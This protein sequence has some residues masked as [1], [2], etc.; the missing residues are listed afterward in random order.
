[1]LVHDMSFIERRSGETRRYV[2]S[3]FAGLAVVIALM[4]VVIAELSWRGWVQ[5]M[6]ALLHGEGLLRRP[7]APAPAV[8]PGFQPI[9]RDLQR[10]IHKLALEAHSRDESQITWTADTLRAILSASSRLRPRRVPA[11]TSTSPTPPRYG[12]WPA[13]SMS[14]SAGAGAPDRCRFCSRSST[15]N[16]RRSTNITGPRSCASS[17][18]CMTA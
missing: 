16:R 14:A 11:L 3:F 18:A 7:D 1:M 9:A 15:I 6:R 8:R 2:F 12:R 17:A 10:L 13:V 5:G 4:T